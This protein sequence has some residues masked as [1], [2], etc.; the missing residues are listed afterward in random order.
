MKKYAIVARV[1]D[2]RQSSHDH[3]SL[4]NQLKQI[5][6]YVEYKNSID[7]GEEWE[8]ACIIRLHG[9]S[10]KDSFD[11][12]EFSGLKDDIRQGKIDV[13]IATVL[14]RF[15]RS[16]SK[17][18]KFF[19]LLEENN[20][21][22]VVTNHQIDTT[23]PMGRMVIVIL[24]ALAEMERVQ[25]SDK[26]TKSIADR[27]SDGIKTGGAHVLGFDYDPDRAGFPKANESE[28]VAV[29]FIFNSFRA[30]VKSC[31]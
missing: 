5:R 19:E 25:L 4:D 7:E 31:G 26:I 29:D 24:M 22:L 9:V 12:T 17:F 21:D 16:V 15:G 8:E 27:I 20:V 14:D 30:I 1:S 11:S 3:T 6:R 13:V 18:L 28:A 10:G 23:S 2:P